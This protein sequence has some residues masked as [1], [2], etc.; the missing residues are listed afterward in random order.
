MV[1]LCFCFSRYNKE[2]NMSTVES[3]GDVDS[4]KVNKSEEIRNYLRTAPPDKRMPK[5]VVAALKDKGI[6]VGNAYVS[7]VKSKLMP[8]KEKVQRKKKKSKEETVPMDNFDSLLLAKKYLN[9]F[10]GDV[11]LARKNLELVSKLIS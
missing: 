3:V 4:S 1:W 2:T 7:I 10:D 8:T 6:D 11:S 9:A 5:D